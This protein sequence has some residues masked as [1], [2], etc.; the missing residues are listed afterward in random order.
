M[1]TLARS[2]EESDDSKVS[3]YDELEHV[4]D[5]FPKYLIKIILDHFNAKL[6]REDIFKPTTGNGSLHQG[7]NFEGVTILNFAT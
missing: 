3:F 7:S 2:E 4:F 1:N 5:H 6:G